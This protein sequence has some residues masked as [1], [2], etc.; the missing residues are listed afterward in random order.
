MIG[1]GYVRADSGISPIL[2]IFWEVGIGG[3]MLAV[4]ADTGQVMLQRYTSVADVGKAIN[5]PDIGGR[6]AETTV[7][8]PSFRLRRKKRCNFHMA[9]LSGVV[10]LLAKAFF[11]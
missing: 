10:S 4:D 8:D 2:P 9:M 3:A 6:A 11:V 5:G 1:R 7:V